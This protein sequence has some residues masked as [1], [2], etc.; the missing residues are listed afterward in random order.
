MLEFVLDRV[1]RGCARARRQDRIICA[2]LITAAMLIVV[3]LTVP[4]HFIADWAARYIERSEG[5]LAGLS[6]L[7][8][9]LT[10]LSRRA[11]KSHQ[12]FREVRRVAQ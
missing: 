11:L 1:M 7:S 4:F 5:N 6:A 9:R 10:R 8:C 2:S 3:P 12:H